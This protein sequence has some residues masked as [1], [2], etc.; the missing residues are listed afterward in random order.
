MRSDFGCV[1][2]TFELVVSESDGAQLPACSNDFF[3]TQV[4]G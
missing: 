2:D 1:G 3:K 4:E